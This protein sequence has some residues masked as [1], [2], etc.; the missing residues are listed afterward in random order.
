MGRQV[1]TGLDY[2]PFET[3]FFNDIKVRK[4]IKY[5]GGRSVVIYACLLCNIYEKGYYMLWDNEI[6][7]L[8]SETTGFEEGYIKE[9]IK[10]CLN[11][12][13]FEKNLYEKCNV[14]TSKGIQ[15]R[16]DAISKLSKRKNQINEFSLI[17]SE[18]KVISSEEKGINSEEIP[19]NSGESAQSKVKES[20]V[21]EIKIN[22]P[23]IPNG[24]SQEN[25][26]PEETIK[27]PEAPK[28]QE[29]KSC[30]KK[31]SEIVDY[32]H[33]KCKRL[34]RVQVISDSRKK[35]IKSRLNDHGEEKVLDVINLVGQSN[36]LAGENQKNWTADFDWI[37]KPTNFIKIME[38]NYKNREYNVNTNNNGNSQ[39][40]RR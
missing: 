34:P 32:F 38:G 19:I 3:K 23:I 20:K 4:L 31:E 14:I 1:K 40:R 29:E 18:E 30:A 2:F 26:F 21:K 5:Q 16:Y 6:P 24:D 7:F 12:G 11:I 39:A 22:T 36:F 8:V 37:F 13:L 33:E 15:E 25:L 27:P 17:N 9:V 28:K 35:S 10:C